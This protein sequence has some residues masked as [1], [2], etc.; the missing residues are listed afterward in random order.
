MNSSW[1]ARRLISRLF[2][3]TCALKAR[4]RATVS[5][6]FADD[7]G[8]GKMDYHTPSFWLGF[9]PRGR[10]RSTPSHRFGISILTPRPK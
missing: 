7:N 3:Q 6:N 10:W 1:P 2:A 5:P 4:I 8:A 9:R